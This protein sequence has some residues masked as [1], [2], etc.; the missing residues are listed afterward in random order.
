MGERALSDTSDNGDNADPTST[1]GAGGV[2]DPT[3]VTLP[4]PKP[5]LSITKVA[6]NDTNRAVGDTIVYT[7]TVTNDGDVNVNNIS[8]SESHNALGP[9]PMPD[10]EVLFNDVAPLGDSTDTIPNNGVW[11][12][13]APGDQIRF[14]GAYTVTQSDVDNLQ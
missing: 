8:L 14:T 12:V 1:N 6:D 4:L 13:L 11:D 7:Y 5:S 10:G 3:P 2:D 9:V